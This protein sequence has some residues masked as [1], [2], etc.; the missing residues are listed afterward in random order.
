MVD[1]AFVKAD[2]LGFVVM[3]DHPKDLLESL[4]SWK[5]VATEKHV[6]TDDR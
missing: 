6:K 4:Q 3:R 5:L 2:H 1:D